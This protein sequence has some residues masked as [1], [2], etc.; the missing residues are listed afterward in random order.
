MN[1]SARSG[2]VLPAKLNSARFIASSRRCAFGPLFASSIPFAVRRRARE[3]DMN[4]PWPKLA[5]IAYIG[6]TWS[7]IAACGDFDDRGLFA[8]PTETKPDGASGASG[9]VTTVTSVGGAG[10]SHAVGSTAGGGDGMR[11]GGA[12]GAGGVIGPATSGSSGAGGSI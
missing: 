12:G 11:D 8:I 10:G 1:G 3:V 2:V 6:C 7:Q 9:M 4:K 5:S